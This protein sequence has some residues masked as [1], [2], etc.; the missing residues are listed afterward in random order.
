MVITMAQVAN[1]VE[2]VREQLLKETQAKADEQNKTRT[3]KGTR[4][5]VGQTRGKNPQVITFENFDESQPATLPESIAEFMELTGVKTE[6]AIV[7]LLVDGFN[8]S[9]YVAASD[10]IAEYVNPAWGE[11]VQRQF[12]LVVRNYSNAT[13]ASIEEAVAL[14]KPGIEKSQAK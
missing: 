4:L 10:P 11:D 1:N 2:N 12:R 13:G 7:A 8:S 3:G 9:A 5:R 14:I 6:P